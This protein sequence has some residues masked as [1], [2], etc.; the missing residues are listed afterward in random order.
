MATVKLTDKPV[1]QE[2]MDGDQVVLIQ[3]GAV[4]RIDAKK[5]GANGKDGVDGKTPIRGVDYWTKDDVSAMHSYIDERLGE[6]E[7]GTY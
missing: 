2:L 4:R 1:V 3:N 7:N 5:V 6:I